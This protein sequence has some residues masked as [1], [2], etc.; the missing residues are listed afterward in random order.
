[1]KICEYGLPTMLA[2]TLSR[3]R[4]GIPMTTSSRPCSAHWSIAASIIGI[5]LSAPSSENRFWPT[6][7][8]CRNVSKASAA[9]SLLRMYF[10]WA[11]VGLTCLVSTRCSSHSF[12]SGSRIWAYSTPMWRQ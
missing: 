8:V 4:C 5:T 11:T 7:L 6:Y 10:C 3:P 1:M 9:L 12:C 2:S